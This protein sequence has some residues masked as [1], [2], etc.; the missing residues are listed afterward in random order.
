MDFIF[1]GEDE[2]EGF[3]HGGVFF[4]SFTVYPVDT[5]R[6]L[7]VHKTFRKRPERLLNVLCTLIYVLCLRPEFTFCVYAAILYF[8]DKV[9]KY[10]KWTFTISHCVLGTIY[11]T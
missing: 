5:G 2:R 4:R 9:T 10:F 8:S 7:N 3:T 6:K 1:W 11:M